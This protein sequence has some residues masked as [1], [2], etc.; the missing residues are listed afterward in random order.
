LFLT[1]T[2]QVEAFFLPLVVYNTGMTE[3]L[4]CR[5][6]EAAEARE[7]IV[8]VHGGGEHSGRYE[9]TAGR[10]NQAGYSVI[11]PDLRGHG[12]S[13]GRRGHIQGFDEYVDDLHEVIQAEV[14]SAAGSTVLLGHSLGGLVCTSYAAAHPGTIRSLALTSPLWG[15]TVPVPAWKHAVACA[16]SGC[17]PSLSMRRTTSSGQLLSHDPQVATRYLSDPL[18]H[19]QVSCRLYTE[20]R[21]QLARLPETLPKLT[22]PVLVL[23]AGDDRVV[24][25]EATRRLFPLVGASRKR[26]IMY[27]GYYHEILNEVDRERVIQDLVRWLRNP[28]EP[29]P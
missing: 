19:F 7:T 11:A 4:F 1:A 10:L 23:Q 18:V 25:A 12:R 26:L 9:A 8:L 17:W 22:M 3:R 20:I 15:L 24:S 21:S 2:T 6:W 14:P 13:S 16:L 5:R 28:E 27:D 29:S